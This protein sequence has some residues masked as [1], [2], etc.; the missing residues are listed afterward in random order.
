MQVQ[1][2]CDGER[3]YRGPLDVLIGNLYA[4]EAISLGDVI[5]ITVALAQHY[6][7]HGTHDGGSYSIVVLHE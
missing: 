4:S 3:D 1:Y 6:D 5:S 2:K 7:W